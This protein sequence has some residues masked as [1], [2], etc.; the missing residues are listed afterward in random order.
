M[1][2]RQTFPH[3]L[4]NDLEPI[5]EKW[6]VLRHSIPN[7]AVIN[8]KIAVDNAIT[9]IRNVLPLDLR[10]RLSCLVADVT[11]CFADDLNQTHN[12]KSVHLVVYQ[13]VRCSTL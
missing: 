4:K 7:D 2:S 5:P 3:R 6:Q 13:V 8:V 1:S 12:R 10:M 11:R 9:H